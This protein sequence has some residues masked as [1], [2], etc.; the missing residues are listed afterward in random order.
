MKIALDYDNTFTED[1][2][3]W[4]AFVNNARGRGHSVAF[5]TSRSE[6]YENQDILSDAESLGI[7]VVFCNHEQKELHYAA[8][9]W[10]DDSPEDIPEFL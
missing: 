6:T 5:V 4:I 7:P 3:L 10:I 2:G 1:T 9:V 8:H